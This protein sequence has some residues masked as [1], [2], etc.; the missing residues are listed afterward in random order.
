MQ[1]LQKNI[2]CKNI[3]LV[4]ALWVDIFIAYN[5]LNPISKF[6]SQFYPGDLAIFASSTIIFFFI[7]ALI[8]RLIGQIVASPR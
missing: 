3:S 8:V 7:A 2:V 5:A 6:R 1:I 4:I